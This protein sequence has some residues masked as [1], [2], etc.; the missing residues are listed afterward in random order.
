VLAVRK[1][2]RR[3]PAVVSRASAPEQ[4]RA[5]EQKVCRGEIIDAMK[6][7]FGIDTRRI[8]HA[9]K[10]LEYAET[11]LEKEPGDRAVV[12]A[13]AV[14]HD[15]GIHEAEAR[16]GSSAGKYQEIEGPPIAR[17]ILNELGFKKALVDHVCRI[18]ANHHSARD[19]DTP[20][21][22]IIWD[23]DWLVNLPDECPGL[24]R[25]K[26]VKTIDRVFRTDTGRILATSLFVDQFHGKLPSPPGLPRSYIS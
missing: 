12:V 3:L 6:A 13:A 10:V 24:P 1:K 16:H 5:G 8:E 4:G 21:F 25:P 11:I 19:I 14:L 23:A 18:V 26:L 17:G 22:R 7:V 9:L 20:E 2:N 15:I